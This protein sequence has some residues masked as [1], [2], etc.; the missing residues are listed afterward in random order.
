[1]NSASDHHGSAKGS[2]GSVWMCGQMGG[3]GQRSN[4][5][6]PGGDLLRIS[7]ELVNELLNPSQGHLFCGRER[8]K[9]MGKGR[10]HPTDHSQ[11]W[12]PRF[13]TPAS[14]TS[15]LAK[16][17]KPFN[18]A[19]N[20]GGSIEQRSISGSKPASVDVDDD[21]K[22]SICRDSSRVEHVQVKRPGIFSFL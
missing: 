15:L 5:L 17:P 7:T 20:E 22:F 21:R 3:D 19:R 14:L 4:A 10:F 18:E 1:M 9:D 16:K 2:V 11:S 13:A 6:T 8:D 12:V